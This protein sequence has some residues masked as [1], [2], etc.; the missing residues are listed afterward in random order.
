MASALRSLANAT[1]TFH[2]ATTGVVTD[3]ETG[4]VMPL[5]EE[6]SVELFVKAERSSFTDYPG[7]D[8]VETVYEGYAVEPTALDARIV[9]GTKA[10]LTFGEEAPVDCEV[11]QLRMPYGTT[12]VLG[13]TLAQVLGQ[14]VMLVAKAQG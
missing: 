1:A 7:V 3:A 13:A 9:V 2:V 4:N 6:V 10:A 11:Q 5:T 12:G 8:V 14:K